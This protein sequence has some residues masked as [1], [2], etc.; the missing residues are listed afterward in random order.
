[1]NN[2]IQTDVIL[3][4]QKSIDHMA[5]YG[6]E[7]ETLDSRFGRLDQRIDAMRSSLSGLQS[8]VS[9]ES[10]SNLRQ[11]LTNELN[12][13][14]A[15]NGI[16]LEQLGSAGLAVK[17]ETLQDI[18]GKVENEINE[19]LRAH[20]RNMHIE[21]DPNYASGQKLPI[22]KDGFDEINKEVAKVIN[23]QIRNLVSAIQ[24][25]KSNLMKSET[26]DRLQITIGKETVMAFVNKIKQ[27]I[28][29]M[30]QNPDVAD[31]GD[32]EISKADLNK[33]IKEAKEKLLKAL[34]VEIPDMSGMEVADK[35]KR[36]P[37]E[38]EQSLNEY[39]NK[40]VAGIN[41]A[42]A[43]KMQIPLGDLS[44]KVK[45]ILAQELDT[46]VDKLEALGTVDLG[47]IRGAGLKAQLERVAK[48]LDKKLSNNVQE[49]IDQLITAI[50]DVQIT[51]EPKLKHHLMNQI[52]RIN[53]ALINKIREQ[54]NVQVQSIIQEINK[55]QSGPGGLNSDT[56][57]RNAGGLGLSTP[58][59]GSSSSDSQNNGGGTASK[60][61]S[62]SEK[63]SGSGAVNAEAVQGA[64][65]NIIRQRISGAFDNALM[66]A[67][68]KAVEAFKNIQPEK[69][70]M[71]QN[72][73]Q[74]DEYNQDKDG[75]PLG[76][77]N[78]AGVESAVSDL[79]NFIR[80]Q[81][82]FYGTDYK[83][84][85][86]VGGLAS[87][88]LDDPVE[89]KE[90]VRVTAQL[91]A[92][93]P[94]S[95]PGN[96]ANG[97]AS[98]K[99]QF[100]LGVADLEDRI[101]QP[102]AVVSDVT[103]ASIE[104]IIDTL[105]S[106]G[107]K[108][109]PE[110]SIV[111]AGTTLQAKSL[112]GANVSN[113]YNSILNRL[114]S[115]SALN[116]MDKSQVDPYF[117]E[118]SAEVAN[119]LQ[120]PEAM[121][122]LQELGLAKVDDTGAKILVPAE[123]LF[124]SI[125]EKLSGADSSTV[126]NTND[127][128]FGT[129]QSSKGAATMHEIMNTFVKVMEVSGNFDKS[130]YENMVKSSVD[131]PLVN[132]KRAGQS[133]TIAFDALVQ[134]M[135][136]TINKVS[137]ALMNMAE[138]VTKNAQLFVK[139]GDVLSNVLLGMMLLKGIKWGAE[140]LRP[141]FERETARTAFLE[142]VSGMNV[143]N[144]IKNMKRKEVGE[145]QKD[146]LL[147]GYVRELNGMTK[148]QSDHFKNYLKSNKIEV[149]DL[150]TL[151]S[152]MG[153]AKNWNP[154]K[155]LTDDEK[156]DR[157]KQYNSR[158]STRT[159]LASVI[160]PTLLTA[161]NSSTASRGVFDTQRASDTNYSELS[162][163]MSQMS[164][165]EFQGFEDHLVDRQRNGLPPIDDIQ[166]LNNA[167]D[168]YEQTQREAAASARQA[169]PAF[170]D[171][172][173]A[174]RGMNSSMSSTASL[175]NG[176]KQFLKDI[177]DLGKGA[178]VSVKNLA[179]GFAKMALEI[180]GAIG[181]AQAA[182]GLAESYMSTDEE[183]L[184][185]QADDRDNDLKGMANKINAQ[186]KG[187][188]SWG[189][190]EATGF[191]YS[192]MNGIS[193]LTNG[194]P[195]NFGLYEGDAMLDEMMNYFNFSG[196]REDFSKYLKQREAV[197]GQTV[198]E[199]VAEFNAKSGRAAETEKMRQEAISKQYEAT[200]LKEAEDKRIQENAEKEYDDK[201]KEGA[202]Q[203]SSIDSGSV[204]SRVSDRINEIKDTSQI[205][206]LRA[207]MGGMKTDSDEYIALRKKQTESMR[208]VLNEELAII[209][210][211]IANAKA[212]MDSADPESQEYADAKTAYDNLT[213]TRD[214]VASEGEVDILQQEWNTKQET[215][216]GQVR[217]VNTSLSRI[218]L[219]AQAKELAAAYN[220]DTQSQE[221]LDTMKKITLNKLSQM[222]NELANLQAIQAIG[223][224]SEDQATQV[225]QLQNTIANEQAL[226]KEYNLASIGIGRAKIQD[227]SSERENELL[228]LKLRTGNPDDSS[229][230]LRNKRIANAKEEVSE[231]N[232][233]I[234]DLRAKLPAAG[235]D[236]TTKI[237]AEIRDLQKQS[238]QAQLGILD[239]MKSTAGTFNMPN[240]VSAMSRYE[241]LTRG[242]THNTTTIG[243]GDVTVNITLP[244]I[245]NG[246]TNRQLQ[247][248][249]QS[250]GQG[251]SV[252]RV[253]SLRSQQ[254]MNPSNYR[255]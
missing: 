126:R 20:V 144:S 149:K 81:S 86:Q 110:T 132:T 172:S 11:S 140:K 91:N 72:L 232:Q 240:G 85:Y 146:P 168:D 34:D 186:A 248:V 202:A 206:T 219:I 242:N 127:A 137:Y 225:L 30:L 238:L 148:E 96:I 210:K 164:Q 217:K 159:E 43:G 76:T 107:S 73:K 101:A 250:I 100:G 157:T 3:E 97:L 78:M 14:I 205:D 222:K 106:S 66:M 25:Q 49:E 220:M 184:L 7:M 230:I 252:G 90:F 36:I 10:G 176:F 103:K 56:Q 183:R 130:K 17:P 105:K 22:T 74:K 185:A 209:D 64:I 46:T 2:K 62:S 44:K 31:A 71:M 166:K 118:D 41:T 55:V 233:V 63:D 246:M 58:R 198:E 21:I 129:Y 171:L 167:M 27:K 162:N 108:V 53:N 235:A 142:N 236:E 87:G 92:L 181:L 173:N 194:T 156:F 67:M 19:E 174:V 215:Y 28:V 51:P 152:T 99:A 136:P 116:K 147:G 50:N 6:Q 102:L 47:S 65:I 48:A 98:T 211:Y 178:L 231:I 247:Q 135:T 169:S 93:A 179:G 131:N 4:L 57:I 195:S 59:S 94:G 77:T 80:Q 138:N 83:Q 154:G 170:G 241:Y 243:T 190:N 42:M 79:Q 26:L 182:K 13:L 117:G 150:P 189:L 204:L 109:D 216:Q 187:G 207:L 141:N 224:L 134:E 70:K 139:L 196:S 111:M 89:M 201:Y 32:M 226:I 158:L 153:E 9:R 68:S 104:Q 122:K 239:E 203:F 244:N 69:L 33:V 161:L 115:P 237:N 1:M 45:K 38:L 23:L 75:N 175:K 213:S 177:P 191:Y 165:G 255:S 251:L 121:K 5:R 37:N 120:S 180:A 155:E 249:G 12:N 18:L 218:D 200:K 192:T 212:V 133:I 84:L 119:R 114:Q 145:M 221:Y 35:V 95:S 197:G 245:T 228:E 52:N 54:V 163:R 234:A 39:V 214:K 254:A 16:V 208:Q 193:K 229:P 199:A 151:F 61:G 112:E 24:K 143:D 124:K 253:G 227:N 123:E 223:D 60:G 29:S 125:A 113:F 88:L 82:M 160:T 128:L 40:T 15:R 188:W 8:Q